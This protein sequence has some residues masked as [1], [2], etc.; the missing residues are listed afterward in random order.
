MPFSER[1]KHLA[2]VKSAFR[3]CACHAPF[4]EVHHLIP[5]AEGGSSKL[6]NAAPLCASCHDLYGGNP[7]KRKTLTQ[8]RD[9]WWEVIEE[10]RKQLT[11]ISEAEPAYE[12]AEDPNFEG[13]LLRKRIVIYH[14]IFENES[15]EAAA[16]TLIKL[17]YEAQKKEP[18]RPRCLYLDIE[19][20]RNK[21]GGYD[22]DMFE[23]QRHFLLAFLMPYL[24]ELHMPLGSVTNKKFQ[25]NDVIGDL[26]I[27]K[28]L[29]GKN[30]D[31]AI[32]RGVEMIW[33]A[34]HD[35]ALRLPKQ[36]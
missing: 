18:N 25:R 6:S 36:K 28:N 12:I 3:C 8:M 29:S 33:L 4:V 17:V 13:A 31:D 34:N 14:V 23:L 32:T 30:I 10:R 24:T 15:F 22:A 7:E 26:K 27:I 11:D 9:N 21:E 35:A 19:G 2:K 20:H 5:E 16:K 1:V